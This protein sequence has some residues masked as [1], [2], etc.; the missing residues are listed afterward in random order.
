MLGKSYDAEVCSIS[1]TLEVFGERWTMLIMRNALFAGHTR[2]G[3]FQR[4]LGL[5][6]N[7]LAAR[8]EHLVE[9]NV[10]ERS[11]ADSA[12]Y[13]LTDRGRELVP[14]L[15]ALTEWGDRWAAP[16]G[17]PVLYR[18][19]AGI[20]PVRMQVVCDECGPLDDTDDVEALP[21]PGMP[22]DRA[23]RMLQ[24]HHERNAH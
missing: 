11:T 23:A 10:M 3:E 17:K 16:H 5:A 8:L 2:F 1:R 12:Q 4:S 7:I 21:G 19:D 22:D 13:V 6:T 20:H 24:R 18:H 14:A 9:M 15:V